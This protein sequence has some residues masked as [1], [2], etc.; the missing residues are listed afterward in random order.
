MERTLIVLQSCNLPGKLFVGAFQPFNFFLSVF[1][2]FDHLMC[3][4]AKDGK[5]AD[6]NDASTHFSQIR[7]EYVIE[8][9]DINPGKDPK[10]R[11][12][13]PVDDG[14]T[15]GDENNFLW[16]NT[17]LFLTRHISPISYGDKREML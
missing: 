2:F 6:N 15:D 5:E 9:A 16:E 8:K 11:V 10:Y 12:D 4:G 1:L 7:P 13:D 17:F 3:M 14:D